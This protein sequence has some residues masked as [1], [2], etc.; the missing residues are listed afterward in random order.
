MIDFN[1]KMQ[2]TDDCLYY[3]HKNNYG[4]YTFILLSILLCVCRPRDFIVS[5]R[6]IHKK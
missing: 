5:V 6:K 1:R 2:T 4:D 3:S